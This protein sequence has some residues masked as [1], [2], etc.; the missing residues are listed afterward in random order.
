MTGTVHEQK[1]RL[2]RA[3]EREKKK[4]ETLDRDLKEAEE[5]ELKS[6]EEELTHTRE[7]LQA[8]AEPIRYEMEKHALVAHEVMEASLPVD[9]KSSFAINTMKENDENTKFFTGLPSWQVFLHLLSF[10]APFLGQSIVLSVQ[11]QLLMVLMRLRLSL[12]VKDLAIRFNVSAASAHRIIQRGIDV[13]HIRLR[14]LVTWPSREV[15]EHNVPP[16]IKQLYPAC[17]CIIDCSEVFIETPANFDARAKVYSNYK[18]HSTIKFLIGITPCG[19]IS[20]VSHAWGG[21]VSDKNLTQQSD[22]LQYIEP[23]DTILADRGFN[24]YDDINVYGGTLIIPAF[25]RGKTQLSQQDVE[26]SKEL[27]KVRV[28][29]ERIIGMLKSKYTILQGT[30][31]IDV[32]KHNEDTEVANIDKI[33]VVCSALTN[34]SVPRL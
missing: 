29:V 8:K 28:H 3:E 6:I 20:Y 14:F 24:I 23:G 1:L 9:K 18:H 22:F 32:I 12:L 19:A 15:L 4:V 5:A 2:E 21:R 27:S 26:R 25:T 31:P 16:F 7:Q 17:R 11:D 33:L 13:M 34:I 10:L 30:L